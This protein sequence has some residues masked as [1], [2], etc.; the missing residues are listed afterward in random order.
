MGQVGNAR[1]YEE[2]QS[3]EWNDGRG[4]REVLTGPVRDERYRLGDADAHASERVHTMNVVVDVV[5]SPEPA[6]AE[7]CGNGN[8]LVGRADHAEDAGP[9]VEPFGSDRVLPSR[10]DRKVPGQIAMQLEAEAAV[11]AEA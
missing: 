3:G 1:Q 8:A 4:D 2:G 10:G 11:I 9:A 5:F 6:S 7:T